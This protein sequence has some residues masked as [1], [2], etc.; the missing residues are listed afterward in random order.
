MRRGKKGLL[1]LLCAALLLGLQ[2]PASGAA[3][4]V[5]LMAVNDRVVETTPE[6]MPRTVGDVLYVPYIMLSNQVNGFSLGVSAL[7][8][9]TRRTVLVT[10]NQRG[11]IFDLQ[12][13]TAEDIDGV[14]VS[15]RAMMRNTMVFLPID[16]LCQYFGTISC[17]RVRTPHGTLIRVTNSSAILSDQEFANAADTQLAD[18]LR[19]YLE[20]VR[21]PDEDAEPLPTAG[22]EPS[23]APPSGAAPS[24]IF[25]KSPV[26]Q[27]VERLWG[28]RRHF[29]AMCW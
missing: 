13:N 10:D 6:N 5:N 26:L 12:N 7:Y 25:I 27:D 3:G 9:T 1:S 17:S 29:Y 11:V 14:P 21:P 16:W 18:N 23:D 28:G 24:V 15:A 22:A 4:G 19:R 20:S 2:V 8:S